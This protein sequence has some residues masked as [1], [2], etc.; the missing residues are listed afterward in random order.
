MPRD[1]VRKAPDRCIVTEEQLEAAKLLISKGTSKRKA[2]SQVGL[3]ESTLRKRLKA[4][5]TATSMGRFATTF[6][7]EQEIDIYKY[8]K[9][10]DDLYYGLTMQNLQKLIYEFAEVNQMTHRFNT[11]SKLAGRDWV[12]G[13]LKRFP[14]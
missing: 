4:G 1:Y 11:S 12:Y 13:F 9:Q 7:K 5:K 3:K 6:T 14:N 10:S 8:I 2:A